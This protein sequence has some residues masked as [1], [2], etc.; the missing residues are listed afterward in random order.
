[1]EK[2]LSIIKPDGVARGHIGDVI[3]R[4]EQ[5]NLKIVA[6][7][8]IHMTKAQAEGF[9]AVHKERPFF[10]SLTEFMS[11]GPAVVMV[12]AGDNV[13]ARYRELMGATDCR[14]AAAGTI[15]K[16]FAT[17]IERNVVHGSD[18][19]ETAAFEIGYFFNS[20]EMIAN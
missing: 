9:Y 6:M 14:V 12:L 13:I 15:R 3:K 20:L 10:A 1:M 11:S 18:A 19:P 4:L 2:T 8:M 16:D 17:D 5:N 7:K